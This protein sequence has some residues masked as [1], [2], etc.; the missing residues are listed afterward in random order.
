MRVLQDLLSF[1]QLVAYSTSSPL[2]FGLE[3][4]AS[5]S[6]ASSLQ[7]ATQWFS[8]MVSSSPAS[9]PASHLV[10]IACLPPCLNTDGF[11]VR[12]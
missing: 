10:S 2:D 12:R 11:L 4:G 7:M 9:L 5:Q 8:N 3:A 6:Q 1:E